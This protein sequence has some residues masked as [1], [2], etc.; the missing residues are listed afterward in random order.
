MR[1]GMIIPSD[2]YSSRSCDPSGFTLV[3]FLVSALVLLILTSGVFTLL[4]EIQRT[5]GYQTEVQSVLNSTQIA[6]QA[7]ERYIRQ[8]GNDP[9]GSGMPGIT[10][11]SATEVQLRSDLT[12][13]LGAGNPDKGDPD[14]DIEDSGENV[15]LR[16]NDR[17]RSLEIVPQ[18]GPAQIIAGNISALAFEYFDSYGN[19][20]SV[21]GEVKKIAVTIS[22]TSLLP[23]PQTGRI[24]GIRLSSE[25]KIQA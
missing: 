1:I 5:A 23:N 12:G 9:F 16:Y 6:L 22:G 14:G 13:S 7:A 10:I 17:T 8:A 4:C 11:V 25:V 18:G 19:P 21:G 3:E 20:T 2:E 15:T 24:F